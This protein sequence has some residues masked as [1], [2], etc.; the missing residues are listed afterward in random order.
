M[1]TMFVARTE[2]E[3]WE[4]PGGV[5]A[6]DYG[7]NQILAPKQDV[8]RAVAEVGKMKPIRRKR[9]QE[10]VVRALARATRKLDAGTA[11]HHQAITAAQDVA[12]WYACKV[13]AGRATIAEGVL[14]ASLRR[15]P[16]L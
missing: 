9:F 2:Q 1:N 5:I 4:Q 8:E 16:G 3:L 13:V 15:P 6:I 10:Q 11:T 12:W 14:K 7:H